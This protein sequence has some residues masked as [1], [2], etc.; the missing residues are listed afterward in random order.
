MA[1]PAHLYLHPPA[2]IIFHFLHFFTSSV[3]VATAGPK[4]NWCNARNKSGKSSFF[5]IFLRLFLQYFV[6]AMFDYLPDED[7]LL[8]CKDIGLTL[9]HGDILEVSECFWV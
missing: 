9:R 6:R 7:N 8:P 2:A 3:T 4:G 1:L 5:S